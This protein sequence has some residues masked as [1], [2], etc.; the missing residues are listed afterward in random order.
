VQA[1]TPFLLDRYDAHWVDDN[2]LVLQEK[3][4]SN[5]SLICNA[6]KLPDARL[7]AYCQ[8]LKNDVCSKKKA[9]RHTHESWFADIRF[10]H[11]IIL[12]ACQGGVA[13]G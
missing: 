11:Q 4:T 7:L 6:Q 12:H 3:E 8:Q 9:Q 13:H 5:F 1:L 10:E 2:K